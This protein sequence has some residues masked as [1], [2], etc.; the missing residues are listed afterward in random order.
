MLKCKNKLIKQINCPKNVNCPK[1][2]KK[3]HLD[4]PLT[5][6]EIQPMKFFRSLEAGSV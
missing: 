5:I 2:K 3:F 4:M 6:L 1:K